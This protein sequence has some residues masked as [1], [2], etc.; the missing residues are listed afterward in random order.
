MVLRHVHTS[1]LNKQQ[2]RRIVMRNPFRKKQDTFEALNIRAYELRSQI[3]KDKDEL[4]EVLA[5]LDQFTDIV[6][7]EKRITKEDVGVTPRFRNQEW[8]I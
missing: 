6:T 3:I 8:S 5:L 4:A 7:I 1:G 2:T